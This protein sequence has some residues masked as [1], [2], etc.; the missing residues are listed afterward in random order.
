MPRQ[1]NGLFRDRFITVFCFVVVVDFGVVVV[2]GDFGVF[3]VGVLVVLMI[4][5]LLMFCCFCCF[6]CCC[7]HCSALLLVVVG[8][9]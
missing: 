7:Y 4:L 8:Y 5:V 3:D 9:C 1:K 6:C 2:G